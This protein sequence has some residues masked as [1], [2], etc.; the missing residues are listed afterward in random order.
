ML[1]KLVVGLLAHPLYGMLLSFVLAVASCCLQIGYG[2]TTILT[3][4]QASGKGMQNLPWMQ[5]VEQVARTFVPG[6]LVDRSVLTA[7]PPSPMATLKARGFSPE[8]AQRLLNTTHL[9]LPE[10]LQREPVFYVSL[11]WTFNAIV[12]NLL[13]LISLFF[14]CSVDVLRLW[15]GFYAGCKDDVDGNSQC[16]RPILNK[17]DVI[18]YHITKWHAIYNI[19]AEAVIHIVTLPSICPAPCTPEVM[20]NYMT[21]VA[22]IISA[23]RSVEAVIGRFALTLKEMREAGREAWAKCDEDVDE[24]GNQVF[25]T[26]K[27]MQLQEYSLNFAAHAEASVDF[28]KSYFPSLNETSMQGLALAV[29]LA[30]FPTQPYG[31]SITMMGM[32]I[33]D[34][35]PL[36]ER[37]VEQ[38]IPRALV[39]AELLQQ[40]S[41]VVYFLNSKRDQMDTWM[42]EVRL[43]SDMVDEVKMQADRI[44]LILTELLGPVSN[45]SMGDSDFRNIVDIS[46]VVIGKFDQKV[47]EL[48]DDLHALWS[49]LRTLSMIQGQWTDS[50]L[51]AEVGPLVDS[52]KAKL[53][54][55]LVVNLRRD[56]PAVLLG[57]V[58]DKMIADKQSGAGVLRFKNR[59][60]YTKPAQRRNLGQLSTSLC[61]PVQ[62]EDLEGQVELTYAPAAAE[63]KSSYT[64]LTSNKR[65][66]TPFNNK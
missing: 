58:L 33:K 18:K 45:T 56:F 1:A 15:E 9:E 10:Q 6:P 43:M 64:L 3:T 28:M 57:M 25:R 24:A 42:Q 49:D 53:P 34:I 27:I 17:F 60:E 32:I 19:F 12:S 35:L 41:D 55:H 36:L 16:A 47:T 62:E 4:S 52:I 31:V 50:T 21:S 8:Q 66:A 46:D 29:S 54:R 30:V 22:L 39:E 20:V 13:S 7:A 14:L 40:T 48:T 26:G 61:M 5:P 38:I 63:A 11:W 37:K 2:A 23:I 65:Y 59:W 44:K 51:A